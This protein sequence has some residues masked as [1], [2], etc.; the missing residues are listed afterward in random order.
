MRNLPAPQWQSVTH[1]DS[2]YEIAIMATYPPLGAA[3]PAASGSA[4][5]LF[6]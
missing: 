1:Q 5:P 2:Y 4:A 3:A 6:A